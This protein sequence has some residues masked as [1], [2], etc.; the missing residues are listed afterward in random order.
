MITRRLK[1]PDVKLSC[2]FETPRYGWLTRVRVMAC[3][4][5]S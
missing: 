5:T 4:S 2:F 1:Y 3:R